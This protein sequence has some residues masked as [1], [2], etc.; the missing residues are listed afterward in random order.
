MKTELTKSI[1]QPNV[2]SQS[3]YSLGTTARR[4][5]ALAMALLP[6]E[7]RDDKYRV[8]FS[9]DDFIKTLGLDYSSGHTK[10]LIFSAMNECVESAVKIHL[11]NGDWVAFTWFR[12]C[13]LLNMRPNFAT[14][15]I[16][17]TGVEMIFNPD[18][19]EA[20]RKFKKAYTKLSLV[21]FGKLQSKYA[22]RYYEIAMSYAGFAGKDGNKP[23]K[24]YFEKGI[25][26]LRMLFQIEKSKYPR[27]GNFRI[28]IIDE[29]VKELNE[30]KIGLE[31]NLEYIREGKYLTGVR[32]NCEF[33]EDKPKK[34]RVRKVIEAPQELAEEETAESR[35][36]ELEKTE[37]KKRRLQYP[38]EWQSIFK[39]VSAEFGGKGVSQTTKDAIISGIA[40]TRLKQLHRND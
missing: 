39:T 22:I 9:V 14:G 6:E 2:I 8:S 27:T 11:S 12:Q 17:W 26:E 10:E 31:I 20:I 5:V 35:Q 13:R 24:W 37:A 28:Y 25:K 18:L 21:N 33:V 15:E 19:G 36:R 1:Y 40:D 34:K 4:L 38:E 7:E 30:A 23:G 32:F 29:P 3:I 16:Y